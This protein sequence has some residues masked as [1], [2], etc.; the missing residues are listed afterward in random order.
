MNACRDSD[1]I[2]YHS[3]N[4][5]FVY[6]IGKLLNIPFIPASL[7]PMPT[8]EHITPPLN[9]KRSPGRSF[10]LL[11]HLVAHQFSWQLFMPVARKAWRGKITFR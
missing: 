6:Y 9:I 4:L 11:S 1:L 3:Y 2:I 7:H 8:R 5:P 10:N